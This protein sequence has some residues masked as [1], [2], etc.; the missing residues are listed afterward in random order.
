MR[1]TDFLNGHTVEDVRRNKDM[2]VTL[3][4]DSG[5][6][7]TLHVINGRIEAK[8]PEIRLDDE[9]DRELEVAYSDRMRLREAFLGHMINYVA[10]N[11]DGGLIFVCEPTKHYREMYKK[12]HGHREITVSHTNGVIN[13]LPP[14]SAVIALPGLSVFGQIP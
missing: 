7:I 11:K 10:Y 13:E 12:S 4:C 3:F 1:I 2:S 6:T 9:L 8:P 14:V 5:R